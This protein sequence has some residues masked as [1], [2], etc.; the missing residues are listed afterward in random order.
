MNTSAINSGAMFVYYNPDKLKDAVFVVCHLI[1]EKIIFL[2]HLSAAAINKECNVF[3]RCLQYKRGY[4][5][6]LIF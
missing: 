2:P 3:P 4:Y 1:H 5:N 6:T